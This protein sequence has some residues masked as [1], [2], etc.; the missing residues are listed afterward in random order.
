MAAVRQLVC[1]I[2]AGAVQWLLDTAV[3]VALS[4]AGMAV[5]VSTLAGRLAGAAVGF[6][7]NGRYTFVE[8][9]HRLDAHALR[10]FALFWLL[11]SLIS[12]GL[13]A[14]VARYGGLHAAWWAKP[15]VD[16]AMAAAGFIAARYWIYRAHQ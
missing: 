16:A 2:A 10:R 8:S 11:T 15:A 5:A 4:H 3:M 6:W 9:R 14:C 13:L 12:A 1:F 7:L